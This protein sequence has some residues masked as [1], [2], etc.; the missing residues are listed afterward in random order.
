MSRHIEETLAELTRQFDID[1]T[2]SQKRISWGMRIASTIGGLAFCAAVFLFFYRFWGLLTTPAQVAILAATPIL[3]VLGGEFAA[4]RE[5]TL[6]ITSLILLVA[7]AAFVL[8][9]TMLAGIFAVAP[10]PGGFLAWGLFAMA[11][12][13]HFRLRLPLVIGLVCLMLWLNAVAIM[14][15]GYQWTGDLYVWEPSL[16]AG[17]LVF[18]AGLRAGDFSGTFLLTGLS[19]ALLSMLALSLNISNSYLPLSM[20]GVARAYQILG[21]MVTALAIWYGIPRR[22]TGVVNAAAAGF[23]VFLYCRLVAAWWDWMPKYVFSLIVGV[24]SL[25]LLAAFKKI[26]PRLTRG[27]LL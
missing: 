26:R 27:D 12:A 3:L 19:A 4:R 14:T 8:N 7:F 22:L 18:A 5:R 21:M 11:L 24:I 20:A 6:Y 2:E 9:L 10:S 15:A 17:A 25:G 23:V 1:S 13:Y 16:L